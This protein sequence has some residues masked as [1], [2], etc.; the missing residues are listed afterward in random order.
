MISEKLSAWY[1]KA[2]DKYFD[3]LDFL[4]KKGL[5]VYKYSDFFE[6]KGVPSFVVTVSIVLLLLILMMM[7]FASQNA[8]TT[9]MVLTLKDASGNNLNNVKISVVLSDN[10]GNYLIKDKIV[11]SGDKITLPQYPQGTKIRLSATKDG[12]QSYSEELILGKEK[13]TRSISLSKDFVGIE[14]QL[15]LI[16]SETK[17]K[18]KGAIV[19]VSW[20]GNEYTFTMDANAIYKA[21]NFPADA[22][23]LLKIKA[24]GYNDLTQETTFVSGTQRTF[25]L[26]PSTASFVGKA[27]VIISVNNLDD[28]AIND[29]RVTVYNKESGV[30]LLEDYTKNG[31][32]AGS[33]QAGIPLRIVAQKM[34]YLT[35]DS[36]ILGTSY[37][38]RKSEDKID[39]TL[40]QGG[41]KLVVDVMDGALAQLSLA[42]SVVQLF[43]LEGARIDRKITTTGGAEFNGLDPEKRI[44]ITAYKEDY[45]PQRKEVLVGATESETFFLTKALAD[46]SFRLDVYSIDSFGD[47]VGGA[48]INVNIINDG[49][50]IPYGIDELESSIAGY[51]YFNA[52]RGRTYEIISE[53][54]NLI[55]STII[56]VSESTTENKVYVKLQKKPN[57][58][59]IKFLDPRGGNIS[60]DARVDTLDGTKLYDGNIIN[61][62]IFINSTD[63]ETVEVT[64]IM[65]DGNKFVENVYVKGK[66]YIEVIVYNKTASELVPIIEFV[67]LESETGEKVLGITPNEFYY[68]KFSVSFPLAASSGGLHFRAGNDT[69]ENVE[70]DSFALFELNLTGSQNYYG[71]SYTKDPTPGNEILDR[72]NAGVMGEPN[73]WIE[74]VL[75]KPKGTYTVKVK[76][77]A[78][79]FILGKAKIHYRAWASVGDE[80]YRTPTDTTLETKSTSEQKTGLYADT[81][82][83]ELSMYDSLPECNE[84]ICITTNFIDEEERVYREENFE[85]QMK[86]NYALEIE[87]SSKESDYLQVVVSSPSNLTFIGT[88]VGTFSFIKSASSTGSDSNSYANYEGFTNTQSGINSNQSSTLTSSESRATV[89]LTKDSKQKVR[90]YF[91]GTSEGVGEIKINATG[92]STIEKDLS[93]KIVTEKELLVELSEQNVLLGRNFT[94]RVYDKGL[95]GVG[96]ALVKI[97]DKDGKVV[98]SILGD[99]TEG[100][101]LNGNYRVQNDL[102]VGLY[103][104]EV[105]A[106]GYGTKAVSLLITTQRVLSFADNINVKILQN[107]K[108]ALV[109][110]ELTNNSDFTVSNINIESSTSENFR[111]TAIGPG[112]LGALQK[113]GV[114]IQVDYIGE[115]QEA[116]LSENITLKINGMVEGK[117]LTQ[118]VSS[119]EATY[120]EKL[121]TSCLKFEPSS[122]KI[123]LIGNAGTTETDTIEVTNNC[124]QDIYLSHR[125]KEVTRKSGVIVTG[126]DI[127]IGEGQTK[128]ITITANNLVD[129]QYSRNSSYSYEISW[130]SNYLSKKLN[131]TVNL[132]NPLLALSYPGQITLWLAQPN[133]S[134]KASAAQ[135]LYITN[136]SQF[137]VEGIS[138]SVNTDYATGSNIKINVEPST[139]VNLLPK[140]TMTPAKIVYAEASSTVSEPVKS[141]ILINGKMGNLS[142]YEGADKYDYSSNYY[143]KDGYNTS[144]NSVSY[145]A[146]KN[147]STG[148]SNTTNVLGAI[149]VMVYYSGYNCLK[150]YPMDDLTYNLS[151]QGAQISKRIKLQNSC[152][153]P[154]NVVGVTASSREIIFMIPRITVPNDN[155]EVIAYLSLA[156]SRNNLNLQGYQVTVQG[157][158]SVS[159]TLI[160][161]EPLKVNIL[162]G[163]NS[164]FTKTIKGVQVNV[165]GEESKEKVSIDVPKPARGKDCANGYC[166]AKEASEYIGTKVDKM[167]QTAQSKALGNQNQ[168]QAHSCL[169]RGFCSFGEL[170]IQSDTFELYLQSDVISGEV[171]EEVMNKTTGYSTGFT[172]GA[173]GNFRV[174]MR[175]INEGTIEMIS[176]LGYGRVIFI[177]NR[178]EGCGHYR[179]EIT[180]AFSAS[181]GMVQFEYPTMM[182]KLIDQSKTTPKECGNSIV[183]ITNLTPIDSGFTLSSTRGTWLTSVETDATLKEIAEKVAEKQ[184]GSKDRAGSGPGNKLIIKQGALTNALAEMCVGSGAGK[185]TITVTI[186]SSF[187]VSKDNTNDKFSDQIVKLITEGLNANFGENCLVKSI[188]GYNCVR[189][190]ESGEVGELTMRVPNK[191]LLVAMSQKEV[192]TSATIYSRAP[193]SLNFEI[194]KGDKFKGIKNITVYEEI[195]TTTQTTTQQTNQTQTTNNTTNNTTTIPPNTL[196]PTTQ[197]TNQQAPTQ[198]ITQNSATQ[199]VTNT[200]GRKVF[201]INYE[202]DTNN[203]KIIVNTPIQLITNTD[204]NS[205]KENPFKKEVKICAELLATT[206]DTPNHAKSSLINN[207]EGSYFY[208]TAINKIAGKSEGTKKEDGII[209]LRT[210]TIH[211]DDLI[212]LLS[213]KELKEGEDNPYYITITWDNDIEEIPSIEEYR[214]R[215]VLLG[216]LDDT[217]QANED[218]TIISTK[219]SFDETE[220]ARGSAVMTYLGVCAITS[221]ACNLGV[222]GLTYL[223]AGPVG[224]GSALINGATS[225]L[226]DCVVP[227]FTV[228]SSDIRASSKTADGAYTAFFE[229]LTNVPLIG[230]WAEKQLTPSAVKEKSWA[231]AATAA[232]LKAS[233]RI[234]ST[235]IAYKA[236]GEKIADLTKKNADEIAKRALAESEVERLLKGTTIGATTTLS[237]ARTDLTATITQIQNQI[238]DLENFKRAISASGTPLTPGSQTS[239]DSAIAQF[240]SSKTKL[241]DA[242]TRLTSASSTTS[243]PDQKAL[244]AQADDLFSQAVNDA[245]T[246]TQRLNSAASGEI[247]S[248]PTAKTL[249]SQLDSLAKNADDTKKAIVT[250]SDS[251]KNVRAAID[252]LDA[253]TKNADDAAKALRGAGGINR[254]KEILKGSM[255]LGGGIFCSI[256]ANTLGV[257][258]YNKTITEETKDISTKALSL[259]NT[260]IKKDTTYRVV[261]DP[262][263]TK[264]EEVNSTNQTMVE[265]MNEELTIDPATNKSKGTT[266]YWIATKETPLPPYQ[267]KLS[268]YDLDLDTE[269]LRTLLAKS[270]IPDDGTREL[271]IERIRSTGAQKI[272][273]TY[274]KDPDTRLKNNNIYAGQTMVA[275]IIAASGK[276]EKEL[277]EEA[278]K[279]TGEVK[280]ATEK[281]LQILGQKAQEYE[282]NTSEEA[283]VVINQEVAK[284]IFTDQTKADILYTIANV[285]TITVL[286]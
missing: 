241:N 2:E 192:C 245:A 58:V 101:G 33:I 18:V 264:F 265:Q 271:I 57:I 152:A 266:L 135:P 108:T 280:E 3:V 23:V 11:S 84:N 50:K 15:L 174:E 285:W 124:G 144:K 118:I 187:Q 5:P 199:N 114:Q 202:T 143:G 95:A 112:L 134:A 272:I 9:E 243:I 256:A 155:S 258:A 64:V 110:E 31:S 263:S 224:W 284:Q 176:G 17:S 262:K 30:I 39:I 20:E 88:Q 74:G 38:I 195:T 41:S 96:T 83:E 85:A 191:T 226:L 127:S 194:E 248:G 273:K 182:V 181:G 217:V 29:A 249:R 208:I 1:T 89:S 270:K 215:L 35:S 138:F 82:T 116:T 26:N 229:Y 232:T 240:N 173:T 210:N 251:L 179:L 129:R 246:A 97:L 235:S 244:L 185:R 28:L 286:R 164:E 247:G 218:G 136:A 193:E 133:L 109:T 75:Q 168:Q 60:G 189:L 90:F 48:K 230:E 151:I 237:T 177:D 63:K 71:R 178:I 7:F 252:N 276:N 61:S 78:S 278:K 93:F 53:T 94:V 166:D 148:Y 163:E 42:G 44:L 214:N 141:Q 70:S 261:I 204:A 277:E 130:D 231:P 175:P 283:K 10:Q 76:V 197:T 45:L 139:A 216:K 281:L 196:N 260:S 27:A 59:E 81:L 43:T 121:D 102:G 267:R 269:E 51:V 131:L 180:G 6:E 126:E 153:E 54:E 169:S 212:K 154:V 128:N 268:Y 87:F 221:V 65:R 8:A 234:R 72:S 34:G 100:S 66:D 220:K 165:C 19:L 157:L 190:T 21:I 55:G 16:D 113:Q 122:L 207:M 146:P 49:N 119:V 105:S 77:R 183:N 213:K 225:P 211:P 107:Q 171:I 40:R 73:K 188:E 160:G 255:R 257:N 242:L 149:D 201:E 200:N 223:L 86:K 205:K 22:K 282:F 111:V 68:A 156:T 98:K 172:G 80:Y 203:G 238:D 69:I 36:D 120:N 140:Q 14:A 147:V 184:F 25:M 106:T 132:I 239:F 206:S 115:D 198:P 275:A 222:D 92:N 13:V 37:T 79:E 209:T 161:T 104:V 47:S 67:G 170:G 253:A 227:A 46:N 91:T 159:Q 186:N 150:V 219:K 162:S 250:K 236:T 24:D 259:V 4:D 117:F 103:T 56:E 145:Y 142:T 32:I 125:V 62:R 137:P 167:I 123:N 12:Y 233:T 274:A 52:E 254:A 279:G 99:N 158:T 228:F